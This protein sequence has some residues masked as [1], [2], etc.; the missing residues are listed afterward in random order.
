MITKGKRGN[1]EGSIR[2]R[3][4]GLWEARV[5]LPDG[6][7]KSIYGKTRKEVAEKLT[8]IQRD[9]DRGL[10]VLT[11]ER[12]TTGQ[13]LTRW[14]EDTARL[15][16]RETTFPSYS[17]IV[18]LHLVPEFGKVALAK[19]TPQQI[20]AMIKKKLTSG[21]SPRRV[22]YI[23][24]VLRKALNDALKMGLVA[25]NVVTLTD[26]PKQVRHEIQPLAPE[27][28]RQFLD[29]VRGNR[30]EGLYVAALATGLRQGEL[31]GLRWRDVDLD[32]A[33]LR[34]AVT[35]QRIDKEYRLLEPKTAKSRR[36]LPLPPVAV[37]AL[38]AHRIRQLEERLRGGDVWEDWQGAGLVFTR[39]DGGPLHASTVTH[40]FQ[41]LLA[42]AGL[43]RV[44]FHDLR[45]T[46]ATLLLAQGAPARLIME[47]LGHSQI[48]LT[49]NTYAHV[50]PAALREAAGHMEVALTAA[51][52]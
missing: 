1:S 33:A 40:H 52:R 39:E 3:P 17:A 32:G 26:P 8:A 30:L 25:R 14:L 13:F 35:L 29:A 51:A 12:Q 27:Q 36:T 4:D 44:R 20:Q 43:P 9:R 48:S 22:Q 6:K 2:Q 15:N 42:T 19:L 18:R 37:A 16:V 50:M 34:V 5:S 46:A 11:D 41:K 10:P 38:R 7:R 45:H 28:A 31:L 24:S 21:L 49:M 47:V 23:R